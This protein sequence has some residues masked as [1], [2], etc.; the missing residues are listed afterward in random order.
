MRY[1]IC[2]TLKPE[3]RGLIIQDIRLTEAEKKRNRQG[4]FLNAV[5]GVLF[6]AI[7]VSIF[8]SACFM[9]VKILAS[10]N[11]TF[12]ILRVIGMFAL[13]IGAFL[14]ALV[15]AALLTSPISKKAQKKMIFRKTLVFDKAVI[16]LREYY[17]WQDPCI[18]T[19]CYESSNEAF[20]RHDVCIFVCGDELRIA[21]NLKYGFSCKE[22]DLGCY[23]FKLGEFSLAEIQGERFRMTELKSGDT[24]FHLG[25]RAKGFIEKHFVSKDVGT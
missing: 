5:A 22:K 10:E 4:R 11:P 3:D 12:L 21:A 19:K 6:A 17:A 23:A 18:V 20:I 7:F 2:D 24:V 14:S 1:F 25:R 9:I 16:F 13:G 15:V 8:V